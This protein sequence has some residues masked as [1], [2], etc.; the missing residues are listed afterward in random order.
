MLMSLSDRWI[1]L[2]HGKAASTSFE[3]TFG[4]KCEIASGNNRSGGRH[5][6]TGGSGKHVRYETF[7]E[8]FEG[9]FNRYLPIEHYF[10]FGIIREP[11]KR[12][13]S[14]YRFWTR[15][16]EKEENQLPGIDT[17]EQFVDHIVNNRLIGERFRTPS[18]YWFF[19]NKNEQISINY[20]VRMEEMYDSLEKMKEISGLDFTEVAS[21]VR[22]ATK[23]EA[24]PVDLG[25]QRAVEEH[26]A[27]DYE[28]YEKTDR[29]L[30]EWDRSGDLNVEV[31]LRWMAR[32]GNRFEIAGSL[33]FKTRLRL[34]NDRQFSI[35]KL[36]ANID[37]REPPEG[38]VLPK[39]RYK[40]ALEAEEG[41]K[42]GS[43]EAIKPLASPVETRRKEPD[44][45][46]VRSEAN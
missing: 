41:R 8:N 4:N 6:V 24:K 29:L 11:M 36:L 20:L 45:D 34:Q 22:N 37:G 40:T 10:T 35:S 13:R 15:P 25:V 30:K 18:Q 7:V 21:T 9:F 3:T 1:F 19:M 31:A 33:L 27:Q 38:I 42:A 16:E 14:L 5:P 43:A 44:V 28:L 2:A 32:Q 46:R 17:F 12:L 23:R 26:F 39:G